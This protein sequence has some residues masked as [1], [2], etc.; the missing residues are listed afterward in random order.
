MNEAL[1]LIDEIDKIEVPRH[2]DAGVDRLFS[3]LDSMAE[4]LNTIV[5]NYRVTGTTPTNYASTIVH[6]QR[7][8][9]LW[10]SKMAKG[11]LGDE[12]YESE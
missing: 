12:G 8:L 11:P 1:R 9:D 4:D 7:A 6:V 3:L 5:H 10:R 2:A